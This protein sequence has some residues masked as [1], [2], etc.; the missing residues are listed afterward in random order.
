MLKHG[1]Q[2][3]EFEIR[4]LLGRGGMGE[5]YE[6]FQPSLGRTVALKVL[7]EGMADGE[8][9]LKLFQHEAQF[10]ARLDH[11]NIVPIHSLA[12]HQS[13]QFFTMK[14]VRGVS[15]G[16]AIRWAENTSAEK[17]EP[18]HNRTQNGQSTV[19]VCSVRSTPG[20][21]DDEFHNDPTV[22]ASDLMVDSVA[23]EELLH[24][25]YRFAA[26]V[27][28]DLARALDYA[29]KEGHTHRDIKPSN[30]MIDH[31]GTVYLIDFGLA[32]AIR[33]TASEFRRGT[34]RYMSPE[35][36]DLRPL[37]GRT[38][39]Y[40]LGATLYHVVTGRPPFEGREEADIARN[41]RE[42]TVPPLPPEVPAALAECIETAM[43]PD[44]DKRYQSAGEFAAALDAYLSGALDATVTFGDTKT[45]RLARRRRV[46]GI[47][48]HSRML[49]GGA[50]LL[51]LVGLL[52]AL[53]ASSRRSVDYAIRFPGESLIPGE[54]YELLL[55]DP[56][57]LYPVENSSWDLDAGRRELTVNS[58]PGKK[59][60]SWYLVAVG[61]TTRHLTGYT[62]RTEILSCKKSHPRAAEWGIF[63]G[64]RKGY[65]YGKR[66]RRFQSIHIW[67]IPGTDRYRLERSLRTESGRD[68]GV[69]GQDVPPGFDPEQP[70][71]LEITVDEEGLDEV[72]LDGR[73][74]EGLITQDA[75]RFVPGD[76]YVGD[77]G[78]FVR[79]GTMIVRNTEIEL[80][81]L[82]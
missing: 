76:A 11:P 57:E 68:G 13:R 26:R 59:Q 54:R 38:D 70:H 27:G 40:S 69:A 2:L 72:L 19:A 36:L 1:E 43:H 53:A 39:I 71:T 17:R 14:L 28:R 74:M 16:E 66:D 33:S 56:V 42:G 67:H 18:P 9:A 49:L 8:E 48:K 61:G 7:A 15:L 55:N 44:A 29:H 37:D 51:L 22:T 62:I 58:P 24:D 25:R 31:H 50:A 21:T 23:V 64:A 63:F 3:G 60:W 52:V 65:F 79:T 20:D 6:A 75:N 10:A 35:Q 32:R 12:S 73:R 41:I 5:V 47:R 81:P 34:L 30:V 46:A 78:I 4:R 45:Q 80:A 82:E 77:F